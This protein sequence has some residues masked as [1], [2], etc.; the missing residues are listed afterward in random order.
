MDFIIRELRLNDDAAG[1]AEM[2]NAS[3]GA[4]PGGWTRG[5]PE[6]AERILQRK[7]KYDRLAQFV[8]E[9]SDGQI[10]GYGDLQ[11]QAGQT[12]MAYLPL[13]NVRPDFH[14]KGVGKALVLKILERTIELG[15]KQLT[16]GTWAGNTKAMPLYKKTGFFWVPDTSVFM[17]NFIPTALAL[18]L[19]QPFF[20]KHDW[21]HTFQ[22]DLSLKPDEIEWNGVKVFPYHFEKGGDLFRMIVDK[23]AEQVTAVETNILRIASCIGKEEVVVG[24][25]HTIRWEIETKNGEPLNVT[26]IARGDDGILLDA[27]ETLRVEGKATVEKTF[28]VAPDIKLPDPG[29]P[30][31]MIRTTLLINGQPL[32]LGTAVKPVQPVDVQFTGQTLVPH[33]PEEKV[34]VR[35]KSNLDFDVT[36]ALFID[37]HPSLT[38]DALAK[39]FTLPAHS[40]TA[41]TFWAE[42]KEVGAFATKIKAVCQPPNHLTTQPPNYPTTLTTKP[43]A[44]VFAAVPIEGGV[45]GYVNEET[46]EAWLDSASLRVQV[47]LRGGQMT[48]HDRVS[49]RS[50]CQQQIPELG[51]P[52]T[53]WRHVP[54]LYE[55][56]IEGNAI[57]LTAPSDA[58]PGMVVE[59]RITLTGGSVVRVDVHVLNTTTETQKFKL[60]MEQW[61]HLGGRVT[62]PTKHGLIHELVGGWGEYPSGRSSDVSNKPSD[63][64]ETWSAAEQDGNVIGMIWG[65]CEE[66]DF[67]TGIPSMQ[68]DLPELAPQSCYDLESLYLVGGQGDWEKVRQYWRWLKQPSRV[69][70]EQH[71]PASPVLTASL[72]PHP[73]IITSEVTDV[74]VSVTQRRG[75][76]ISGNGQWI[77]GSMGQCEFLPTFFELSEVNQDKPFSALVTVRVRDLSPRV[78][79]AMLR[80]NEDVT[81]HE[82]PAPVIVLGN[83]ATPVSIATQPP[84][85]LIA[86]DIFSLSIAPSFLGSAIA[87]EMNGVNHLRSSYPEARPLQ[88]MNQWFGGI[89]GFVGWESDLRF[90]RAKFTGEPLERVGKRGIVWR[91]VKVNADMTHKDLKWLR[92][93]ME[94]LTVGSS[95]VLALVLRLANLTDCP[96]WTGAGIAVWTQ[97][98]G[99]FDNTVLRYQSTVPRYE[100]GTTRDHL[101][102]TRQRRRGE[103]FGG[104]D[105][106]RWAAVGNPTTG[107]ALALVTSHGKAGISAEDMGKDGA[108]LHLWHHFGLEANETKEVIG[109]LILCRSAT[110]AEQYR[111]LTEA[112]DLP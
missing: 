9:T 110:E 44:I 66:H 47:R 12:E 57:V 74:T 86:N 37:P 6:T 17:Q 23:Q 15:Y 26:L 36:G 87:L 93:E 97:P 76:N 89:H 95:N 3:D 29:K 53:G 40:W 72:E 20:Q 100:H 54:P 73:L 61:A 109:Y 8:A 30:Q 101:R 62:L 65:V 28:T 39:P 7:G 46:K 48:L 4:W 22:R 5:I 80:L 77:N 41:V 55:G 45:V 56:R 83:A 107:D 38:F 106:G 63:Y 99:T 43:K 79:D 10:V 103:Y 51:P 67:Q 59:K 24:L 13:L 111:M 91:G 52:F 70:E 35:L 16:I 78:I 82:F 27:L 31:P 105:S 19:A 25:P 32:N 21:Y 42:A 58:F 108:H 11:A 33:K 104:Y 96:Q 60:R 98:G 1:L 18:P 90:Q 84:N 102:V 68:F 71:P 81:S 112:V 64:A 94:Y 85:Y 2:W 50:L 34:V 49:G 69:R 92:M 14:G 88:W 75:K